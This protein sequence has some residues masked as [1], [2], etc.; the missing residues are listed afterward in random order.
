MPIDEAE[1]RG[2]IANCIEQGI[3]KSIEITHQN[4]CERASLTLIYSGIDTMAFLNMP[5]TQVEVGKNDFV[6]WADRYINLTHYRERLRG[7]DLYGARCGLL[8][9]YGVES[10]LSRR[11]E[12]RMLGYM[13]PSGLPFFISSKHPNLVMV[14]IVALKRAFFDGID[15]FM[16][17][18]FADAE[19]RG[20]VGQ[21][22][23][24]FLAHYAIVHGS[25][26]EDSSGFMP[27]DRL[28]SLGESGRS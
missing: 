24:K 26:S 8:H 28:S 3:K 1:L 19:K 10:N 27:P 18:A 22:M 4:K 21:R 25:A 17:E 15:R 13:D 11:G 6:Q 2:L 9:Q 20:L 16:T 14:S 12:C 5:A 23:Q 7:I